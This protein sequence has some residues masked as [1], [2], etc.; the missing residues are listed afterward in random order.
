MGLSSSCASFCLY[1]ITSPARK[2]HQPDNLRGSASALVSWLAVS[3]GYPSGQKGRAG[4]S[5][6]PDVTWLRA[7]DQVGLVAGIEQDAAFEGR[8]PSRLDSSCMS[9][10]LFSA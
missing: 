7:I 2:R 5:S 10:F 8:A 9:G 4:F 1:F 3:T 6:S